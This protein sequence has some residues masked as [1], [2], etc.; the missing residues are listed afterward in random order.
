[1]KTS[2]PPLQGKL[3]GSL[4]A[5]LNHCYGTSSINGILFTS[6]FLNSWDSSS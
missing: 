1:L 4:K 3:R 2:L 5:E 6:D